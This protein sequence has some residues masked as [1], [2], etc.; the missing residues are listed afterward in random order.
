MNYLPIEALNPLFDLFEKTKGIQQ[1]EIHHP[2]GDVLNHSLQVL[3]R[4]FR[5]TDDIDLILAAMFH[6]IGK[7]E[8]SKGHEKIGVSML[9]K[10][11]ASE[12]TL[13]LVEHHMRVWYL[14]L[15]EMKKLGK[16]KELIGHP[17]LPELILLARW[18][19]MGRNPNRI[20]YYDRV[21]ILNRLQH[22]TDNHFKE[23][24]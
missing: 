23:K 9:R 20:I 3:Y 21:D 2:E 14:I 19:K 17:W 11:D 7:I 5:E 13:W 4:A 18:D 12:K 10:Y 15:G 6:D 8:E 16:V 24:Q 1:M 22:I